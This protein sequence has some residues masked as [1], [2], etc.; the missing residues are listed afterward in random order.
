MA[1]QD[2]RRDADGE[3]IVSATESIWKHNLE[4][5]RE[6][7]YVSSRVL[8][9]EV[10]AD[11]AIIG[12]GITGMTA[13]LRLQRAGWEVCVIDARQVGHGVSGFNSGHLTSMLLDIDFRTVLSHFGEEATRTVTR[14]ILGAID[15]IERNCRDYRIDC[16]FK[17]LEGYLYAESDAQVR[18]LQEEARAAEKA[19]LPISYPHRT[20]LPFA[21]ADAIQVANQARFDPLRYVLGLAEAFTQEGGRVYEFSPAIRVTHQAEP[22]QVETADGWLNAYEVIVATH[23][24]IGFKPVVQSRLEPYRSYVLGVRVTDPPPDALYWDMDDPYHYIRLAEDAQGPVVI[25]GGED[26]KTGAGSERQAFSRLE[27]YAR[28]HFRVESVAYRWSSQFYNPAD[29]LPYIG[30]LGDIFL[31]TGFSGEG[32]TF[33]TLAGNLLADLITGVRN[34]CADILDPSRAKPI[35]SAGGVFSEGL[36]V[37][38]H[39]IQDRYGKAAGEVPELSDIPMG[40]GR[41]VRMDGKK[42]AAYK[43]PAGVLHLLSPVCTHMGCIVHWNGAEKSWDCPCHGGRYDVL[44]R[45]LNGPPTEGLPP[46]DEL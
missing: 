32:L 38:K 9:G 41:I 42:V 7:Q 34:D 1:N 12:A 33:G 44:G 24:P 8:E 39:F 15:E 29:G 46:A 26:H 31:A 5:A 20:P 16:D 4:A 36:Q 22:F 35:A 14:A 2:S 37:M 3:Q 40:E 28:S 17:R 21:V 43:D 23:T 13:A 45:V 6:G 27:A 10:S 30:R 18:D 11:I 19:G 25:V